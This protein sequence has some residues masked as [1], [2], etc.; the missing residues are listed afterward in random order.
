MKKPVILCVDDEKIILDSLER[1][2]T[3][4]LEQ[5]YILEFAESAIE[6]LEIIE[7]Y[8][9]Q[10]HN[11]AVVIS[12]QVMPEMSGDEFLIK[13]HECSPS[14]VKIMLTGQGSDDSIINAINHANLYR[15][16]GKPW[17]KADFTLTIKEAAKSYMQEQKLKEQNKNL[18]EMYEKLKEMNTNLENIVYERTREL[19]IQ[20]AFFEQL[21]ANSPEGIAILD[22]EFRITNVNTAFQ[23]LFLYSIDEV[24]NKPIHEIIVPAEYMDEE[25]YLLKSI[26]SKKIV[27]LESIRKRKD[28][29]LVDV[30]IIGYLIMAGS[31]QFGI[32][33]IYND[34]TKRKQSENQLRY[35]SLHDTLTGLYN[36]AYFEQEMKRMGDMRN[37]SA[38]I[39]VCDIDGLKLINDTL[40]HKAGDSLI[41]RAA[42]VLKE[43]LRPSD[44]IARIGGDE[45]AILLNN[46]DEVQLNS[47]SNRI[48]LGIEKNNSSDPEYI[49]SMSV[50]F[51]KKE[52]NST[53]MEDVFK[54][55]DADMYN[56]KIAK[57]TNAR[58]AIIKSLIKNLREKD[59]FDTGH[60]KRLK[61]LMSHLAQKIG[62][63]EKTIE[64]LHRLTEFHDIGKV[65]I[66]KNII[67]KPDKLTEEE[68][69]QVQKHCEIGYRIA[70][71]ITDMKDIA[72]LIAKHHE[73]WNGNGYPFK[74]KGKEIPLE[75][76]IFAVV[77]AYVVMTDIRPYRNEM[78]QDEAIAELRRFAG[79]QFD[80]E[81]VEHF[82][83][84]LK[85]L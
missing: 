1:Q 4:E 14:V 42:K 34:I 68:L 40:G 24:I 20:K 67:F 72:D 9:N 54:E 63:T 12:D 46:V 41:Q 61:S 70:K 22:N 50:G 39:I 21:F 81:I 75:C 30:S 43:S 73:W 35:L 64:R 58:E 82:I 18:Q 56:N 27:E 29:S 37:A 59:F 25:Q 11:I 83:E 3:R 33:A 13:V 10:G 74:I 65:G 15:Y 7:E 60:N 66:E 84:M 57:G 78:T 49:L 77:D 44:L 23:K 69:A 79:E 53:S 17:E 47:I 52:E 8:I 28:S 45:F 48:R 36:R 38:G 26:L 62:L 55:A 76:R 80:P 31:E 2:L 5:D 6:G 16:I 85:E 19:H 51:A 32:C 71:S